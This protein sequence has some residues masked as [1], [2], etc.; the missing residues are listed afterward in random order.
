MTS[1][2]PLRDFI[3]N[4]V[5]SVSEFYSISHLWDYLELNWGSAIAINGDSHH[6]ANAKDAIS[7]LETLEQARPEHQSI[8]KQFQF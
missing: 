7:R 8:L 5:A 1:G 4:S 6:F 2:E 3:S